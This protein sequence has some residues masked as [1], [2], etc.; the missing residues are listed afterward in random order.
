MQKSTITIDVTMDEKRVPS[1]IEWSAT[2]TSAT[3]AQPA[4]AMMISFWD[5]AEKAAL[6]ID[7]WTKDMMVD[8]MADFFYQT[9][10]TMADTYGRATHYADQVEEMKTFA[11]GF[12]ERFREKQLK[13]NK[14][15]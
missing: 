6:R 3:S 5:G 14:A 1:A 7:L 10:M 11:K 9:M 12:Y 4:K 8:E 2:D 15:N 13:D